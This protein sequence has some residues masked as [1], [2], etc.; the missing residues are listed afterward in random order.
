ME[1][2]NTTPGRHCRYWDPGLS[3]IQFVL[4]CLA[5]LT[6]ER[7]NCQIVYFIKVGYGIVIP[8]G[9]AGLHLHFD[10]MVTVHMIS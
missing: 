10:T 4:G 3:Q 6:N 7:P 9:H 8:G 1:S 2:I 5:D